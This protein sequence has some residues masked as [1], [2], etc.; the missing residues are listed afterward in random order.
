MGNRYTLIA[1]VLPAGVVSTHTLFCL[2]NAIAIEQQH[3]LAA[4]FNS[5]VLNHVTRLLMG[6]HVTTSLVESLPAPVWTGSAADR[7][8]ARLATALASRTQRSTAV[9]RTS[10]QAAVADRFGLDDFTLERLLDSAPQIADDE[11]RLTLASFRRRS[12]R[13][14]ALRHAL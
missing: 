5:Y 6:A 12:A 14:R 7:R 9:L 2:R 8:I 4:L 1:A 13:T 10:L 11:R 3:Y